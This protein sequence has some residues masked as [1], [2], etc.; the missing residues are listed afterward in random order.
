M[1]RITAIVALAV[2]SLAIFSACSDGIREQIRSKDFRHR[3]AAYRPSGV[4]SPIA[5]V[6]DM[7]GWTTDIDG[8]TA[9]S[10]D[11]QQRTIVFVQNGN[12]P[13]TQA[14]KKALND[15]SVDSA[16][17]TS[18][19]RVTLDQTT[20]PDAASRFGVQQTPAVV[21]LS[22]AGTPAGVVQGKITKAKVL[23]LIK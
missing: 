6:A 2:A 14:A 4:P 10:R 18:I 13:A 11:N 3:E 1:V 16:L 21:L 17:G 9:F 19:Q 15:P 8:A 23:A 5:N 7:P 12:S 20:A 22:S